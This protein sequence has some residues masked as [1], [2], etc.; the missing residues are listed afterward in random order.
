[1]SKASDEFD[2]C[3]AGSG[4]AGEM[5][6]DALYRVVIP[7]QNVV[8]RLNGLWPDVPE[9]EFLPAVRPYGILRMAWAIWR[10]VPDV[11]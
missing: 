9:N 10:E 8:V 7:R 5:R 3:A 1:M 2:A 11:A 6:S 4:P